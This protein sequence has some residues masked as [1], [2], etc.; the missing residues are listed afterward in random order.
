MIEK[1]AK[2]HEGERE[3]RQASSFQGL[4]CSSKAVNTFMLCFPSPL[5]IYWAL[6][7]KEQEGDHAR[8]AEDSLRHRTEVP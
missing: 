3:G 7:T 2:K 8:A 6:H 4:F 5:P 1:N